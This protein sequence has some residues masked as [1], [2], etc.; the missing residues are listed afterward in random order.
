MSKNTCILLYNPISGHGHLDSWLNI[1]STILIE[2]GY[3]VLL[4]TPNH[5][6]LIIHLTQR[7]LSDSD[8]LQILHWPTTLQNLT[9]SAWKCLCIR[10]LNEMPCTKTPENAKWPEKIK[11]SACRSAFRMIRTIHKIT[12]KYS[13]HIKTAKKT[14][15]TDAYLLPPG[16]MALRIQQAVQQARHPPDFVFVMYMDMFKSH[17]SQWT[18]PGQQMGTPW[19]GIRFSPRALTKGEQAEG[20]YTDPQLRGMC[21]LDR[22]ATN[23]YQKKFPTKTFQHLPDITNAALPT[24]EPDLARKLRTQAGG[25]HIVILGGSLDTRK[26]IAGFCK[27]ATL[28]DP[29]EWFFALVGRTYPNTFNDADRQA[30]KKLKEMEKI[31]TMLHLDYIEDECNFNAMLSASNIIFAVYKNF[32]Y[33]SNMLSKSAWLRRPIIVSDRYQMGEQVLHYGIGRATDENNPKL[34]LDE[35]TSLRATGIP[36]EAFSR[37]NNVFSEEA[38]GNALESFFNKC[39]RSIR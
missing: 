18:M 19:A 35:L 24:T 30:L 14:R 27:L 21:F 39:R 29:Q 3:H 12:C 33:S 28:A 25:R 34:W 11:K 6:S 7:G 9:M 37:Y 36:D 38:L 32:P 8:K 13:K 2:R 26:N 20:H 17:P 15:E 31:N 23:N 5:T 1:F 22:Q 16:E 4:L 10:Y